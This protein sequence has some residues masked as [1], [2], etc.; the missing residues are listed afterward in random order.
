LDGRSVA[1]S[2][3]GTWKREEGLFLGLLYSGPVD[4]IDTLPGRVE[5]TKKFR[6][7]VM[8]LQAVSGVR[9]GED[10]SWPDP[11]G[12]TMENEILI[13]EIFVGSGLLVMWDRVLDH[14]EQNGS[15]GGK[16]QGK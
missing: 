3:C 16:E 13:T 1:G 7:I 5:K 2:D 10:R 9:G 12:M 4:R 8:A 15:G 14:M 11:E 6:N